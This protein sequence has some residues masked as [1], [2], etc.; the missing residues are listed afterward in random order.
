MHIRRVWSPS[1]SD[2]PAPVQLQPLAQRLPILCLPDGL[3]RMSVAGVSQSVDDTVR[4][5]V[6]DFMALTEAEQRERVISQNNR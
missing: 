3:G 4:E 2:R 6:G 5:A 1:R